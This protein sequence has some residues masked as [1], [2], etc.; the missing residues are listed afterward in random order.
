MSAK[1][2]IHSERRSRSREIIDSLLAERQ[3]LLVAFCQVAG[4]RPH[5]GTKPV[6]ALLREFCQ[7]L[8][9]YAA[10]VHFELY[11]RVAE[12]KERRAQVLKAAEESY[13]IVAGITQRAVDFN[14]K[15]DKVEDDAMADSLEADLSRLGEE[16]ALRFELE[17]RLFRAL[18]DRE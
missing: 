3:Q 9:D 14:D 1:E 6:G 10:A 8:V 15:Y 5:E 17:D 2:K 4:L 12:G 7:I 11:A 13:P 18:L 16:L